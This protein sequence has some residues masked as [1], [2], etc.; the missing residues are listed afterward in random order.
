MKCLLVTSNDKYKI[1]NTNNLRYLVGGYVEVVKPTAG[2]TDKLLLRDNVFLCDE[3]GHCK[4]KECNYI[5]TLLYNGLRDHKQIYPIAGDIVIIGLDGGDLRSL[6]DEEVE[7]YISL[8]KVLRIKE[9][10]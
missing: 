8:L 10:S 9:V 5:G 2:Y 1:I 7:Y 3:E 4:E 6:T